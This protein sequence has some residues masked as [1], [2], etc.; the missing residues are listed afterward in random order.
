MEKAKIEENF[1][2]YAITEFFKK[3]KQMLGLTGK[4]RTLTTIVHEYVTNSLDA[5]EEH[6]ILPLISVEIK[7]LGE[8]HYKV[9]VSD[10]GPGIPEQILPKALGKML[11]EQ[12]FTG[13][14]SKEGNK[15]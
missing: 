7:E 11:L 5:C 14:S 10:N 8:E 15:A 3:N 9:I 1:R 4:V 12:N 6:G 2:E 13:L